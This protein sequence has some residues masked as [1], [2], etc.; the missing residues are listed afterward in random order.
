MY[1]KERGMEALRACKPT[2]MD[3]GYSKPVLPSTY[4]K[5]K[6]KV[7]N[8]ANKAANAVSGAINKIDAATSYSDSSINLNTNRKTNYGEEKKK[9]S[10]NKK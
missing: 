10:E 4:E 2:M 7:K 5:I 3:K 1:K 8:T 6:N 9:G